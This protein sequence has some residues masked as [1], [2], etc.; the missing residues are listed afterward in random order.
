MLFAG[1][2]KRVGNLEMLQLES[3]ARLMRDFS[4]VQSNFLESLPYVFK[5]VGIDSGSLY[6]LDE[7]SGSFLLKTWI[8]SK[9][10]GFSFSQDSEFIKFLKLRD[11]IVAR[12]EFVK[13]SHELRQSAL[14]FFQQTV[15]QKVLPIL[16]E[17][18]WVGFLCFEEKSF[19]ISAEV[20]EEV[21]KIYTALVQVWSEHDRIYQEYKK[22]SEFGQVKN[23]LLGNVTH[24]FQ[25]PLNGILGVADAILDGA[26]GPLTPE[27]KTHL[28]MIR[29]AG[30]ELH[31]T[32][33]NIVK[34]TQVD[35]GKSRAHL[36]KVNLLA[37]AEE[38][39]LLFQTLFEE[40]GNRCILPKRSAQYEVFAEPD[41]IRTVLMNLIGNAVKFTQNGEITINM[42]KSGEVLHVSVADTG[43]GIEPEKL[44]MIFEEF[45]QGDASR[46]R[47]HGGTGLGLALV[48]KIVALHGGRIW[49]E[50]QI[51]IGT[52]VHFTLPILPG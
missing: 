51:N 41:Q 40:R 3:L 25:T 32:L 18:N 38:V 49:A 37:L 22:L 46:T 9:P 42:H 16:S 8:G 24:E 27:L 14:F 45:Y 30:R 21:L 6:L 13:K 20:L 10:L 39:V 50:S 52:R 15:A 19:G 7:K 2:K 29:D 5:L 47:A 11:G 48:K 33:S 12:D 4:P 36:E 17:K 43:C 23:E 34:L 1:R 28:E 44:D 35:A 26:D 31:N